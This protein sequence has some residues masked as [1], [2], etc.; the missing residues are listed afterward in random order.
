[1]TEF[2]GDAHGGQL[3]QTAHGHQVRKDVWI[4]LQRQIALR[5][6]QYRRYTAKKQLKKDL[7]GPGKYHVKGKL[8]Q[9]V[10]AGVVYGS[11]SAF[12]HGPIYVLVNTD[13][14]TWTD[15]NGDLIFN[16]FFL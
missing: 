10:V 15:I 11:G 9:D 13:F 16:N 3:H 5:V 1:M 14:G 12:F 8:N 2:T 7:P 4:S 6:S